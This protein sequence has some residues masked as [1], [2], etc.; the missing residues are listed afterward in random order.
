M[1]TGKLRG[2]LEEFVRRF[3]DDGEEAA[4]DYWYSYDLGKWLSGRIIHQLMFWWEEASNEKEDQLLE[5]VIRLALCQL[6]L[7]Y[8]SVEA[9][10]TWRRSTVS[11]ALLHR[12]NEVTKSVLVREVD[13]EDSEEES[14]GKEV[15]GGTDEGEAVQDRPS[16][17]V[18]VRQE[19]RTTEIKLPD[20]LQD[21]L[22][23]GWM[24]WAIDHPPPDKEQQQTGSEGSDKGGKNGE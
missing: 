22:G 12:F 24:D 15:A 6:G 5:Q 10:R 14:V 9:W 18:P 21:V 17:R 7:N 20:H 8:F 13:K 3:R 2:V 19:R 1:K 23:E 4:R 11:N 16:R